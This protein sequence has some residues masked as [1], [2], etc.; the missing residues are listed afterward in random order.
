M[1]L[2][3]WRASWYASLPESMHEPLADPVT[4]A[5]LARKLFPDKTDLAEAALLAIASLAKIKAN[6]DSK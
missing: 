5:K 3:A 4:V 6:G 2:A 1:S